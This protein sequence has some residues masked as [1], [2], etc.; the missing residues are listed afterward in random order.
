MLKILEII[1]ELAF[2]LIKNN[3][4]AIIKYLKSLE[5]I[6][7]TLIF[8]IA[9]S[10]AVFFMVC[11]KDQMF[12]SKFKKELANTPQTIDQNSKEDRI[13]KSMLEYSKEC[14]DFGYFTFIRIEYDEPK[15][16]MQIK[17]AVGYRNNKE[18]P[19]VISERI[20]N[21]KYVVS[22][23]L[24]DILLSSKEGLVHFLKR[25]DIDDYY[26][27]LV[28]FNVLFKTLNGDYDNYKY[29]PVVHDQLG[30]IILI[31]YLDLN[32]A[33]QHCNDITIDAILEDLFKGYK[34]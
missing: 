3:W 16:E 33:N 7:L 11:H 19:I 22:N 15:M 30:L 17:Y 21:K 14:K 9:M 8:G 26:S 27:T 31:G 13:I 20:L 25:V 1:G 24:K 18:I 29:I 10:G 2:K 34:S 5:V 23:E 32:K 28:P 4:T 6:K 12:V